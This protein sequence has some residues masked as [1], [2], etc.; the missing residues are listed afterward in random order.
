MEQEY[1][2][3]YSE[4]SSEPYKYGRSEDNKYGRSE[5]ETLVDRLDKLTIALERQ[6]ENNERLMSMIERQM[7][8][9]ERLLLR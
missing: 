2:N 7:T 5:T 9:I 8:V 1:P 6:Q 4:S 3:R